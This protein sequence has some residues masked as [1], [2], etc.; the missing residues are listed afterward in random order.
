MTYEGAMYA[1]FIFETAVAL[2]DQPF[3]VGSIP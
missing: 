1:W 3:V 2:Y